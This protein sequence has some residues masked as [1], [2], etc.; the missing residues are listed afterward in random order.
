MRLIKGAKIGQQ[1][2]EKIWSKSIAKAEEL[3]G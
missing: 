3:K 1:V 2:S